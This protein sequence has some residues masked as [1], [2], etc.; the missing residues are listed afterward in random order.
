[1][2][3]IEFSINLRFELS[4]FEF[5]EVCHNFFLVTENVCW[6]TKTFW[7]FKFSHILIFWVANFEFMSCHILSFWVLSHL[8]FYHTFSF[9]VLS[10]F[11]FLNLVTLGFVQFFQIL[12][13]VTFR[14]FEFCHIC[15]L[16]VSSHLIFFLIFVILKN[17]FFRFGSNNTFYLIKFRPMG[18]HST[19]QSVQ[20]IDIR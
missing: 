2:S 7:V 6:V 5:Y 8:Q 3:K 20:K 10:H 1:M 17:F 11:D 14:F 16:R 9:W 18:D 12:I 19:S 15:S 4:Q 13:F